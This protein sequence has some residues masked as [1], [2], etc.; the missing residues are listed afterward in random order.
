MFI[1]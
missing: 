1:S